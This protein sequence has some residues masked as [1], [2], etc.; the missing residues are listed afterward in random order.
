M[1]ARSPASERSA[2]D[3]AVSAERDVAITAARE[4]TK[5]LVDASALQTL[6]RSIGAK[7]EPH[8]LDRKSVV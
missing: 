8:R 3:A 6:T 2:Q 5:Y 4:E 7:L 1:N